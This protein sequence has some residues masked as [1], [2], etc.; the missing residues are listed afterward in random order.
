M[1]GPITQSPFGKKSSQ[2]IVSAL[3]EAWNVGLLSRSV[4]WR[5]ISATTISSLLNT[6]PQSWNIQMSQLPTLKN[7]FERLESTTSRRMWAERAALPV[8]SKYLQSLFELQSSLNRFPTMRRDVSK[9]IMVD[10]S[11][12]QPLELNC[13]GLDS[14]HHWECT[15]S[16][17]CSDSAWEVWTGSVEYFSVEWDAP[18]RSAVRSLMDGGKGPPML[19]E[20][21]T[22]LR[23]RD[24]GEDESGNTSRQGDGK[25]IYEQEKRRR[26]ES[27]KQLQEPSTSVA[28]E[29]NEEP[30]MLVASQ[31]VKDC[32]EVSRPH[33]ESDELLTF[34]PSKNNEDCDEELKKSLKAHADPDILKN[35]KVKLPHPKLPV[36]KVLCVESWKGIPGKARRVRWELTGD[37]GVYR[38]GGDGGKFDIV[39]VEV[40]DKCTRVIKRHP[41]DETA[42]QCAI[43]HGFGTARKYKVMLRL[44]KSEMK[45]EILDGNKEHICAGILEWP[46]FG[47][48]TAVT[49]RFHEDGAI[50]L[51]E[52]GL[53]FG[54]KD[55]G[56]EARFGQPSFVTGTT[57]TLSTTSGFINPSAEVHNVSEESSTTHSDFEE[58]LGSTSYSVELL[59]NRADG[60]KLR[61]AS[62][63][64][65]VRSKLFSFDKDKDCSS[66]LPPLSFDDDWHAPCMS[67]SADK[68]TVTCTS[69]EGR[70]SAFFSTGFTKGIHY[71]EVK[72][73]QA[74]VGSVY[75]GV[76][77][78]PKSNV[79][80]NGKSFENRPRLDRWH[81]W[82]FVNFRATYNEGSE[83]VYG[84][85]CHAGDVVGVL[86]DCDSGRLSFFYDGVK[87]GEHIL[88]DLGCAFE[89]VGPFG[90]NADGCGGGGAGQ[91]APSG[92][93]GRG[94]RY[95]ANGTVRPKSLWPIIG[96]CH[97]GDRVTITRKWM[98]NYGV[99]GPTM[100]RNAMLVDEVLQKYSG[101]KDDILRHP[102][103]ATKLD[104]PQ[105]LLNEAFV[106]LK[107]WELGR[108]KRTKTRADGYISLPTAGLNIDIDTSPI[109]CA[110]ACARLGLT[111]VLLPGTRLSIKKSAGRNLEMP[112]EAEIIG[113]F[114]GNIWYTLVSQKSEGGSLTE[115]GGR[116][117]FWDESD[118]IEG[119]FN[120]ID[121]LNSASL[122]YLPL[123]DRFK[124]TSE[125]GLRIEPSSGG[126]VRSGD[127]IEANSKLH[128]C[129]Y[130]CATIWM[131]KY[132]ELVS[133]R[134]GK[135]K[136]NSSWTSQSFEEFES[137][138][139][140]GQLSEM[141]PLES[142]SFLAQLLTSIADCTAEGSALECSY[143]VFCISLFN[144]LKAHDRLN[145]IDA[146]YDCCNSDS[147]CHQ[148]PALMIGSITSRFPPIKSILARIAM[149][150][151]LNRR[152]KYAIPLYSMRPPQEDSAI[153]GGYCGLG[154]SVE[155]LGKSRDTDSSKDVSIMSLNLCSRSEKTLTLY[156]L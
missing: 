105:W 13:N 73:D 77:E 83:R 148:A 152:S 135:T 128:L 70:N 1:S 155:C 80:S 136:Y 71:W 55:S 130:E 23:G 151:A 12:P 10:A 25:E 89:N 118:V 109:S 67:L 147:S 59:R 64:R 100:V 113:S 82:G 52:N 2:S 30:S 120:L 35:E 49:C 34:V 60:K 31:I 57:V 43:R 51:T 93:G 66:A 85:H 92:E 145:E 122:P 143:E 5:M 27:K 84:S 112:E 139:S 4:P 3:F 16:W 58:L 32:D 46:D 26:E 62:E 38:Y 79:P 102:S 156:R 81:G 68:R 36:G 86:L 33:M 6:C 103:G 134:D 94:G 126:V 107:R 127:E 40:N 137:A 8:C 19:R 56:W 87:Y 99:D 14:Q 153:L 88:N 42:E 54:S 116:A 50:T 21:C 15:E 39:H 149:L 144:A 119:A 9:S 129:P 142:D 138:L 47:A 123:L 96:L 91:G 140:V 110:V 45:C 7:V 74:E 22:V 133:E 114:Q 95:P 41:H 37:E 111:F 61:V 146:N 150:R 124:C 44:R 11:T 101:T 106:E 78:K 75:I 141:T 90:F 29:I 115:G 132:S 121:P 24:W 20:G 28:P 154:A 63:M 125:G 108:W 131:S 69:A 72:I 104:T 98:T 48:G 53:L 17:V 65:L 18:G 97:P 76:A 117:W